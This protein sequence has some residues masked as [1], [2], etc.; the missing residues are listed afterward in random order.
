VVLV[1]RHCV[2]RAVPVKWCWYMVAVVLAAAGGVGGGGG[3]R[4]GG[5]VLV[6]VIRPERRKND[7]DWNGNRTNHGEE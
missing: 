2:L 3:G 6:M 1:Y 5:G 4:G 7:C